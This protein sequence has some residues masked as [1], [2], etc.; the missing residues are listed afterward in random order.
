[1]QKYGRLESSEV[2]LLLLDQ[3]EQ[4]YGL[5][6][7]E[8]E[9]HPFGPILFNDLEDV[10]TD[11]AVHERMQQ[12]DK[13]G[14]KDIFGM[15]YSEFISHPTHR[16]MQMLEYARVAQGDKARKTQKTLEDMGLSGEGSS[17]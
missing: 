1:M 4:L 6:D 3:Y 11:G 14:I 12:Y 16:V 8:R 17:S 5:R 15:S 9:G 7:H 13:L 2:Q 10:Y